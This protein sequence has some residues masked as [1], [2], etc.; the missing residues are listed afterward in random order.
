MDFDFEKLYKLIINITNILNRIYFHKSH[1]TLFN[2]KMF[3]KIIKTIKKQ[4]TMQYL[5]LQTEP[6]FVDFQTTPEMSG[7]FYHCF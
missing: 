3:L 1:G 5:Y 2:K 4:S 6:F 7:N